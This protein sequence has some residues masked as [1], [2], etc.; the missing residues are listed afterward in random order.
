MSPYIFDTEAV[1]AFLYDEPGSD[2][3]AERLAAVETGETDGFLAA[4]NASKVY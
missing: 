1:I 4:C 3:V 2:R